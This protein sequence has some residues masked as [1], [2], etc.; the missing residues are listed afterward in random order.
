MIPVEG[1][2]RIALSR[3]PDVR[4]ALTE[5][6]E[7]AVPLEGVPLGDAELLPTFDE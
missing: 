2:Y 5:I 6:P 1:D 4:E 7:A 3:A